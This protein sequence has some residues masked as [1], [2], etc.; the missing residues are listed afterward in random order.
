MN[1][2]MRCIIHC[3]KMIYLFYLST[4]ELVDVSD[5]W[6]LMLLLI[7]S[8][9]EKTSTSK[10]DSIKSHSNRLYNVELNVECRFVKLCLLI[11]LVLVTHRVVLW[12]FNTLCCSGNTACASILLLLVNIIHKDTTWFVLLLVTL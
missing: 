10:H 12:S 8:S 1:Q 3:C 9:N 5:G 6:L 2:R 11:H 4:N 7:V